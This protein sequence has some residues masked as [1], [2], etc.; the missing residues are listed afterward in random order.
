[1]VQ[2]EGLASFVG[3]RI[4][5]KNDKV[6]QLA[7]IPLTIPQ[8]VIASLLQRLV[9]PLDRLI[10]LRLTSRDSCVCGIADA[11]PPPEQKGKDCDYQSRYARDDS[12]TVEV[13]GTAAAGD[14][15]LCSEH[16]AGCR[17]KD[18]GG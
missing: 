11:N 16:K 9:L 17:G 7:A 10:R 14:R 2:R 15:K 13:G 4:A 5:R 1:M 18:R 12:S 3:A 6:E 8:D